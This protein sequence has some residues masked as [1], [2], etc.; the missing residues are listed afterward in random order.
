MELRHLRYF[1]AVV[2]EQSFTKAAE[3]LFIAQPPL[4]RQI[5]NLE[6]ELGIQLFERG[7]RPLQTTQAGHFFYQ[8]AVKLLSNAEEIKSMTKRIG[9]IE[10]SMTIGFVGSL[11]YGLLPRII[12][13]FRQQQPHLNIQLMELST[14]EQLQALKEGRID[15]GFGRLRISDPAVRRIL[16]RKERLVVA[17]HTS[18]PIAQRTEG[19][20]LADLIDEKM[21]MYPT[22]PKPNFSTQLLNIFA[23]HS[24]VPKNMHEIREIQLA[25][26]L[27]A[28]G[29][30][31]C[32][33][34]ASADTIRFPHLNY[35][36]I[37]DNGAVS[38]IFITA[39]AMDRSEDLQSLFD[40][41]YQ[42]YDL[43]GIPYQ[44]TVFTLDQNPI[45][46]S[47]GIDF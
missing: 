19:V 24:L 40:C 45:D 21:F 35:I 12:Y 5:Q 4:S 38:P 11:L 13:L 10:R 34:P 44:R 33:I 23:E 7:S 31:I 28:A 8:H 25:L 16:L 43:E 42:V 14:T 29:E 6:S 30:G 36:P 20:Y 3:K 1:A 18:H 15:V 22:S 41:I 39:R 17:A 27:V 26:G 9:L 37:L 32:I 46:D 47:N 2:E